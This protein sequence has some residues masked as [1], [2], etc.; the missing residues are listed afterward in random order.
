[1]KWASPGLR[2]NGEVIARFRPPRAAP[3][4]GL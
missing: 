2:F 4:D 3:A 1:M